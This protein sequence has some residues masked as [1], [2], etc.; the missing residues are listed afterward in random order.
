MQLLLYTLLDAYQEFERRVGQTT[1]P[2]GAKRA[3]VQA[4]IEGTAGTFSVADLQ[5]QCPGVSVDM[6]RHVLKD[7]QA[8][9]KV[10][11]IRRGRTS[12]WQKTS[13]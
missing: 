8:N 2:R 3:L 12:L 6:I 4:A 1:S 7:L 11:C 13:G 5:R 9:R 10:Q